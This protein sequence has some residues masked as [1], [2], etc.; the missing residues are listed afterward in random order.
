MPGESGNTL[1]GIFETLVIPAAVEAAESL[2]YT[3]AAL[4][5]IFWDYQSTHGTIGQTL[6]VNVPVVNQGDTSDI[7]SGPIQ[8]SDTDHNTVAIVIASHPS[9]SFVIKSW[10]QVRTPTQL[11]ELY[12]QPKLE[13]LLRYNNTLLTSQFNGTNF[14][15]YSWSPTGTNEINRTDLATGW[16]LLAN[17]GVPVYQ[18]QHMCLLTNPTCYSTMFADTA[19]YQAYVVGQD[20]AELAQQKALLVPQLNAV[21]KFDQ[22]MATTTAGK[23]PAL[24][25]HR[26]AVAGLC[27]IPP[28]NKGVGPIEETYIRPV[29][30]APNFV[31][32][33]QAQYDI[34][35]QGTIIHMH[36]MVG[37][38]IVRPEMGVY[39]HSA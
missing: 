5:S 13:S 35:E 3:K 15:V 1:T 7:G 8:L 24:F 21:V 4:G 9:V 11:R 26:Y 39:G 34:K 22:Q 18:Q 28:S 38:K 32:Q 33:V 36:N 16:A 31:V 20:A 27:V 10:D 30:E 2:K 19:F 17:A 29:A 14:S 25:F 6:N 37:Y 12:M 23:Q